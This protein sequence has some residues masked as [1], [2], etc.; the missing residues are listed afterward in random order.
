MIKVFEVPAAENGREFYE[1]KGYPEIYVETKKTERDSW[2]RSFK[3]DVISIERDTQ[4]EINDVLQA[5]GH[6][7]EATVYSQ[8]RLTVEIGPF[9]K[10]DIRC[11]ETTKHIIIKNDTCVICG[12]TGYIPD[13]ET[14][15]IPNTVH[16]IECWAMRYLENL[17]TV[18]FDN[19]PTLRIQEGAFYGCSALKT[20]SGLDNSNI[21]GIE[22]GIF[23]G[24]ENLENVPI[25]F[26][27][28]VT[29]IPERYACGT[30]IKTLSIPDNI[31]RIDEE[32]F[33]YCPKLEAV[34]IMEGCERIDRKAFSNCE[35]LT[36]VKIPD[37]VKKIYENTF[38]GCG[39]FTVVCNPG[40]YAEAWANMMKIHVE[41]SGTL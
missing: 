17:T 39:M 26:N 38:E 23:T 10:T 9:T 13:V 8:D 31:K 29:S 20:I 16:L 35:S 6:R 37:S 34:Y 33:A 21:N 18:T 4:R 40:S 11:L 30:A 12:P 3:V 2:C 36:I 27:Y 14:I 7:A 32:A 25:P 41:H 5:I 1:S 15:E 28:D 22:K 24:C 19:N